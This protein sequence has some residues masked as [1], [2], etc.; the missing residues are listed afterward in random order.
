MKLTFKIKKIL[1]GLIVLLS[2]NCYGQSVC[3]WDAEKKELNFSLLEISGTLNCDA[4]N[5]KGISHHFRN[6]IHKPTGI[7]I[8]P[9]SA[10]MKNVGMLNFF[11]VLIEGGYLTELRVEE[12]LLEPESD[13]IILT[14]LPSIRRQAKV[15][16]KFTFKQPNII[17]M[18]MWLETLTN[19]PSFEIL[20]SSYHAEGFKTGAY[21][22]KKEIGPIESEQIRPEYNTMIDGLYPF[23]PRDEA[24]ANVLTDGR[25]QKGRFYWR[26]AIGRRYAQS[27]VFASKLNVDA[28]LMAR[29]E[30]VYAVGATYTGGNKEDNVAAHRSLYLSL[31]GEDFKAG[32][33]R[34]AQ[35][36]MVIGNYGSNQEK[37]NQL[38][39]SFLNEQV[40]KPKTYFINPVEHKN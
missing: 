10:K 33:S 40:S 17:A 35:M 20:L 21:V 1:I 36:R 28:I 27:M 6:V 3:T 22:S 39:L 11:R 4:K 2:V 23:F 14:W 37:H 18:D 26:M 30:D 15:K 38:Y 16:L 12:P 29:P 8:G 5:N 13:G 34:H 19:Y 7:L 24:G 31:F 32:Q 25:H 9:D